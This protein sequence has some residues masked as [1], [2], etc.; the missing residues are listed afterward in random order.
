VAD[1]GVYRIT[2]LPSGRV[3]IG[4]SIDIAKRFS[5][6]RSSLRAGRHHSLLMQ[7]AW[8]KH[9]R[10][11]FQ[12]KPLFLCRPADRIGAEQVQIDLHRAADPKFGMNRASVAK[13]TPPSRAF[14]GRRHSE[15]S[16]RQISDSRKGYQAWNKGVP[17]KVKGCPRD[18]IVRQK[19]A[20]GKQAGGSITMDIARAMRAHRAKNSTTAKQI[21][22]AFGTSMAVS[23]RVLRGVSWREIA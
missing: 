2:C 17:S 21:A 18:E 10:E 5:E 7:R 8:D 11:A 14:A 6:H 1:C 3:Y 16:R 15:E 13:G 9:G 23:Y 19:I 4:S 22:A 20:A 12:F